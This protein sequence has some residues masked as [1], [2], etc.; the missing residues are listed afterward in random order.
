[1]CY[2]FTAFGK[3]AL[4]QTKLHPD[5][6]VQLAM[7]WAYYRLNRKYALGNL[8][9]HTK[10]LSLRCKQP[11]LFFFFFLLPSLRPGSCYE[12]AMTRKFYHGRTE[13]MRPC[14]TEAVNWCKAMMDPACDVSGCIVASL[15]CSRITEG[16]GSILQFFE[17]V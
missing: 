5:T 17:T 6:F 1:M 11:W 8:S 7:Q 16:D 12:T 2:A 13:T 3:A 10:V 15:C 9:M 14:T 4:K